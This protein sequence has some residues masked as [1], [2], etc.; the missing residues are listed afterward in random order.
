MKKIKSG[1]R[2]AATLQKKNEKRLAGKGTNVEQLSDIDTRRLIDE[3]QMHQNKL[4]TQHEELPSSQAVVQIMALLPEENPNP[5]LCADITGRIQYANKPATE[6]LAQ[7]GLSPEGPLPDVL[8]RGISLVIADA[9]MHEIELPFGSNRFFS[10]ELVPNINDGH[11]NLYGYDITDRKTSEH[12]LRESE[13]LYRAIGESIDY[14]VWVCEPDGRNIYASE[15]FLNLVGL[16]Q[17]QCSNF[18][19]GDVLHPD[20]AEHT[21]AAWQK[22]VRTGGNWDIEHRFRGVDGQWHPVLARGVPVLDEQG[23]ITKWAGINLDISRLKRA[24]DELQAAKDKLELRV[25]ERTAELA[26]ANK[27]LQLEIQERQRIHDI[28]FKQSQLLDTFFTHTITPLVFFDRNFNFIRVN[29][30]YALACRRDVQEFHSRNYFELYPDQ[31]LRKIFEKVLADREVY[32]ALARP[33]V[34]PDHPEWGVTYW[35]WTLTPLINEA[36]EVESLVFALKDVTERIRSE[37]AVKAE[38]AFRKAIEDAIPS[39][40]AIVDLNGRLNYVNDSFCAMVGW[41]ANELLGALPP[42]AFWPMEELEGNALVFR[43]FLSGEQTGNCEIRFQKRNGER[44]DV[45]F[46]GSLL[47]DSR[48]SVFGLLISFNDITE[49]KEAQRKQQQV[50]AEIHDLYN[51][52][53]CGYH[54]LDRDGI[55]ISINNTELQWLG[56][57]R[58]EVIG[59][60]KFIDL[61]TPAS[62]RIFSESFPR[63]KERGYVRDIEFEMVR[64]DGTILPVL[65]NA[66]AVTDNEGNYLM[67]RSTIYDITERKQARQSLEAAALYSRSLIEASLDPLFTISRDGVIMDTN[68]AAELATGMHREG[69]IGSDFA[70]YFT[71]PEKAR[72]AYQQAFLNGFVHD[73][74]LGLRNRTGTVTDILYNAAV[75]KN[76]AGE[77][78][79]VF[80]AARDIT[81]R[82]RMESAL[83]ESEQ[84]LKA[85]HS[86]AHL[87]SWE[88]NIENGEQLWSEE[89]Y[90]IFGYDPQA[91]TVPHDSLFEMVHPDDNDYVTQSV[92]EALE[93]GT[94][95]NV[96]FRIIRPDGEVRYLNSQAKLYMDEL[97]SPLRMMGSVL[98]ITD[99]KNIEREL[100]ESEQ[101]L[102]FL[103]AQLLTAQEMERKRIAGEVHDELGQTLTVLKLRL[104]SIEKQLREDQN[105]VK[106]ECLDLLGYADGILK[107]VRRISRDLTPSV[108]ED[109]GLSAAVRWLVDNFKNNL[110]IKIDLKA[111]NVDS[112][113]PKDLQINIYRILQ[114]CLTNSGKH[115]NAEN[116]TVLIRQ[117]DDRTVFMVEDDGTGFDAEHILNSGATAKGLGFTT[118]RERALLL[119]GTL[120]IESQEGNGTRITLQIPLSKS[121]DSL[122]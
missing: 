43:R 37:E 20:D 52:A 83:L 40:I 80:A 66:T 25:Q 94:V 19:W 13:Q 54:S 68:T 15:S 39:G 88:W 49:F 9:V 86:I 27:A 56:Y 108:L 55:F 60:K 62:Q 91:I 28:V 22:C 73:Y 33:F 47:K 50:A 26:Q 2:K 70:G 17:E 30:A 82:K 100:Q 14:G 11:V 21:I 99:R 61:L 16:T 113:M 29:E 110:D 101:Q 42:F 51:N 48:G 44:I 34:F 104:R 74:H 102:R 38:H 95:Y 103:S 46:T 98:D 63:F 122:S 6:M 79:G 116:I 120:D 114:E 111:D 64:G 90:R 85:A 31:G 18:G 71:E 58:D 75:Y 92:R 109:L 45:F 24:Q 121:S 118:M 1:S 5:V 97:G 81:E 77:I 7:M 78:E 89:M 96:D 53:P 112:L 105:K 117:H 107:S 32:Q 72:E 10:F 106:G 76:S 36:D 84:R 3:M 119:D 65:L 35:D 93:T 87:G 57:S 41:T 12:A 67:S 8:L 59:A 115:A 69:L 23:R 4:E